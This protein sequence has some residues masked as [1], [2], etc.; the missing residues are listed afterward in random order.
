MTVKELYRKYGKDYTILLYGMPLDKCKDRLP[1]TGIYD[2]GKALDTYQVIDIKIEKRK[3][4]TF[5]FS[6]V[7]LEFQEKRHLKGDVYAYVKKG[8]R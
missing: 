3:H 8:S 1:F 2:V 7:D 5:S 4:D 6:I